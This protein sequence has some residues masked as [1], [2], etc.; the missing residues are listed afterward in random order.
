MFR[1]RLQE[2]SDL[3]AFKDLI[4]GE[5]DHVD[6]DSFEPKTAKDFEALART[7]VAK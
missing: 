2:Q 4:G 7:L 1:R 6:L 5:G 3:N